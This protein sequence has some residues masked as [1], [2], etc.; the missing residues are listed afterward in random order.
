MWH[1][2]DDLYVRVLTSVTF[3]S[4]S[5]DYWQMKL[6]IFCCSKQCDISCA[7]F[8]NIDWFSCCDGLKFNLCSYCVTDSG[9]TVLKRVA[10]LDYTR[11][12]SFY[13]LLIYCFIVNCVLHRASVYTMTILWQGVLPCL[14][15]KC[16]PDTG[17]QPIPSSSDDQHDPS[18]KTELSF[19]WNFYFPEIFIYWAFFLGVDEHFWWVCSH[20]THP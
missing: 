2:H 5:L 15:T 6:R 10:W 11:L 18:L 17:W 3:S 1:Y 20:W 9:E 16:C 8:D 7:C 14:H 4:D 13:C 19:S 12:H